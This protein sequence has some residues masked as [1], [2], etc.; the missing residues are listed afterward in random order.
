[1]LEESAAEAAACKTGRAR[2]LASEQ[3]RLRRP[4]L[5]QS[6]VSAPETRND[7]SHL[8]K[9]MRL[10]PLSEHIEFPLH[11]Q[12]F[13]ENVLPTR[14]LRGVTRQSAAEQIRL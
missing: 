3:R 4:T 13:C 5:A 12:R 8:Y 2:A 7:L 11:E 14:P 10:P 6:F 1:M 9:G